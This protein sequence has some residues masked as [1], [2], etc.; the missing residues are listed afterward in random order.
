MKVSA[1]V[2]LLAV[3]S[4]SPDSR[5]F[6]FERLIQ[7]GSQQSGQSCLVLEPAIFAHA[8]PRLADLRLYNKGNETPYVVRVSA[9]TLA[10]QK[11]VAPL[12]L[13]LRGGQIAFD[14]AMPDGSYS[15]VQLTIAA[16]DFIATVVV[17]GSQN[18]EAGA[19]TKLGSF[20]IFDLTRQKLGR[21]TILHLPVSDFR[22]LHFRIGG[23]LKPENVSGLSVGSAPASLPAYSV[24]AQ[25]ST[26]A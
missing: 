8:A 24:V 17:S 20:T 26:I 7:S 25:T 11:P 12:N 21:S 16:R 13:G 15:D 22:Y 10:E 4:V 1:A 18:E 19:E 5:Y 3:V 9:S 14:A 6:Q 2:L 23:P